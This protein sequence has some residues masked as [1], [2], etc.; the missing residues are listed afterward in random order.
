[1]N[2]I[3]YI[4]YVLNIHW[5]TLVYIM[6]RDHSISIWVVRFFWLIEM[7]DSKYL[8]SCHTNATGLICLVFYIWFCMIKILCQIYFQTS[9]SN[10]KVKVTVLVIFVFSSNLVNVCARDLKLGLKFNSEHHLLS[11]IWLTFR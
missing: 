2:T 8:E 5:Y 9:R 6:A 10:V 11:Y 1:M 3:L 4:M 7:S